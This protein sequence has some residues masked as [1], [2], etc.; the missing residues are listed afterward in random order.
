MPEQA[1]VT[2]LEA[3]EAFRSHLIV[4]LSQVRPVLEEVTSEVVRTRIWIE[5]DRRTHWEHEIRRRQKEL[6]EAQQALF[7]ARLGTLRQQ[8][9]AEYL[10]VQRAKRQLEEADAKL[11]IL[12]KWDREY[13]GRT[14]PPVKQMEKLH[15]VLSNDMVKAVASLTQTI[16]TLAAYAEVKKPTSPETP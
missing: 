14:Q 15:T 6:Q 7:S 4:Y 9:S 2:S 12:K 13:D 16:N 5:S 1:R 10:L 11:R 8:T 3:L